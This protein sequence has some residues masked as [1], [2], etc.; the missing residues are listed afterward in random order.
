MTITTQDNNLFA[1]L[2]G[3]QKFP[4]F[5]SAE[6]KY[7]WKVVEAKIHFVKNADGVVEYANFEQNGQKLK[8]MKLKDRPVV[9]IDKALYKLY[10]GKY[11]LGT[12]MVITISMEDD[13]LYA[14]ATNQPR[15]EIVPVSE[16][17]FMAREVNATLRFVKEPDGKVNKFIL[18]HGGQKQEVVRAQE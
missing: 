6:G 5:P 9:S 16:E 4:I 13:K 3:E 11:N 17:E 14:Q 2:S 8:V 12:S 15:L 1:Q 18:D 7:F 10:A